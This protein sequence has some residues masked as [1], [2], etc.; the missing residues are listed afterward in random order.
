MSDLKND[1]ETPEDEQRYIVFDTETTGISPEAGHRIV[2][3][4][5]VEIVNNS[6]KFVERTLYSPFICLITSILSP[7]TEHCF[8]SRLIAS[9]NPIISPASSATLLV[10]LSPTYFAGTE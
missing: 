2:E 6:V 7:F 9:V 1:T 3:L 10:S 4:G 5:C 8:I